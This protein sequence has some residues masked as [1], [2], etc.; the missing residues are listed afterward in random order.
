LLTAFLAF[1][2]QHVL[3]AQPAPT[4]LAVSGGVDSVVMS[5][6]FHQS[7]FSFAIAHCNFGLRGAASAQDEAWVQTLSQKYGVACYT[8]SF[9]VATYAQTHQVS[10]QMAARKLRYAWFQTLCEAHG[11]AQV[12]LAHHRNDS[13]ETVLL[14]LT[15]GTGIAGLRGILPRQGRYIRPLLFAAK[16]DIM[17][18]AQ[19]QQLT[20]REDCSNQ[21]D[22]YQRNLIRN[23]V[24]PLL[25]QINPHLEHTFGLTA[26]RLCQA[27]ALVNDKVATVG[28]A[29]L[30]YQEGK[31]YVAIRQ[32]RRQ[33]GALVLLLALLK[34]FGFHVAQLKPLLAAT[35]RS[36]ARLQSATHQLYVDRDQW[37]I[38]P[39]T[40][41]TAQP[42][43]IDRSTRVLSLFPHALQCASKPYAQ[44]I[45]TADKA[46]AALDQ[47]LLAFPLTVRPWQAGD[48]FYP[49]GMSHRKKIS[50][51]L[52]DTKVPVPLKAEVHVVTSA[53]HIVWVVGHR[54]DERFKLTSSTQ[55]V[56]EIQ[57]ISPAT[58]P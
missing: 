7:Q 4:L 14:N 53:G 36:G 11:F 28:P 54:I 39:R 40:Q 51:F 32:L 16:A 6:L 41:A 46:I 10:I 38:L 3:L 45:I 34:P 25:K 21:E 50:D 22:T 9:A 44:Y 58:R 30:Q 2:E 56:Y 49:L 31:H 43:T 5:H 55:Q 52:I 24:V 13:F 17:A 27:E 37:I 8:Q 12:A 18:Y 57:L 23:Q 26:E 20:W 1:V 48:V 47:A 19:A 33:P 29:L 15:K 35:P 42:H